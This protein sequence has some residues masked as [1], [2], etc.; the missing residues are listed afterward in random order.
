MAI[1]IEVR[2]NRIH[3]VE[4]NVKNT[5]VTCKKAFSLDL[6]DGVLD[7]KGIIDTVQFGRILESGLAS[8]QIKSKKVSLCINNPSIIYREIVV[9]RVDDKKLA[10]VV[11]SEMISSL[12]LTNEYIIDFIILDEYIDQHRP[13]YRILAVAVLD[14][15]MRSFIDT[16]R[17][18][19]LKTTVVETSTSAIIN[20]VDVSGIADNGE[21]IIIADIED[22][23]LKLYLFEE[24][25]YVLTRNT[26]ISDLNSDDKKGLIGVIEDNINK[27]VQ[28]QFTR[29][30]RQGIKHIYLIGKVD[31]LEETS[32]SIQDNLQIESS[33]FPKPSFVTDETDTPHYYKIYAVGSLLRK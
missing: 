14:S 8:R 28:F 1:S 30:T 27:M 31:F 3:I 10:F 2:N 4:A 24:K 13:F 33:I 5:S 19:K 20:Y 26:K 12:N 11:R 9:P 23:A 29:P 22:G 25:K 18:I 21:P 6:P 17:S 16:L 15:A 7:A 32:K